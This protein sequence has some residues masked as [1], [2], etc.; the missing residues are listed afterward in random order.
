M[1]QS[2]PI[3]LLKAFGL[4]KKKRVEACQ[5]HDVNVATYSTDKSTPWILHLTSGYNF[6]HQIHMTH[7]RRRV[8][9]AASEEYLN[10]NVSGRLDAGL[11]SINRVNRVSFVDLPTDMRVCGDPRW[12]VY[13][14]RSKEKCE[15]LS[16]F[17][18]SPSLHIAAL[19]L[20]KSPNDSLQIYEDSLCAYFHPES[21]EALQAAIEV[22][23]GLVGPKTRM[24][25][26]NLRGMPKQFKPLIPLVQKWAEGDDGWREEMLQ[27]SSQSE[28][29]RLIGDVEPY[30][31]QIEEY[32]KNNSD[33]AACA[34]GLLVELT[35]EAK[36][37]TDNRKQ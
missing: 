3:S 10:L 13:G 34:L 17:L 37:A 30:M 20:I 9:I 5:I 8:H 27:R 21:V 26:A 4:A 29:K 25:R 18:D 22:L 11:A 16:R 7:R 14:P 31:G 33:E 19:Q 12:P 15:V 32:L 1:E 35:I 6:S 23:C 2:D 36:L 28:I 24:N